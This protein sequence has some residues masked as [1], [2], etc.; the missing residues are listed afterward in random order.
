MFL[1]NKREIKFYY[2]LGLYFNN[3]HFNDFTFSISTVN[4]SRKIDATTPAWPRIFICKNP[5]TH[6]NVNCKLKFLSTAWRTRK[7]YI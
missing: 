3:L 1:A 5:K 2:K 4:Q 6:V 7:P